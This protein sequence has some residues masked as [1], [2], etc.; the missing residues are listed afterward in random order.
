M[1]RSTRARTCSRS[2]SCSTSWLRGRRPF[3]GSTFI[4]VSSA[5]LR[6]PPTALRSV[7][8]DLPSDLE[9]IVGR[10]LEKDPER[11]VQTAKDVRNELD[12]IRRGLESCAPSAEALTVPGFGGRPAIAV[13]PFENRSGDAEQEFFADG[14]AEDLIARLS[15]WRAFPVIA[16][17]SSFTYKG[18]GTALK[19]VSTELGARYFVQGS[20]RKAG[21]RVR[22]AAQFAD[23]VTGQ[24]VWAQSYGRTSPTYS[25][26]R[27][28]CPGQRILQRRALRGRARGRTTSPHALSRLLLRPG[29]ERD[30]RRRARAVGS[31]A[32]SVQEARRLVPDLSVAML[33]RVLG[34]MAPEVDQR[35]MGA[36]Q[37]AGLV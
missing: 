19:R 16:S 25:P 20:V 7:R 15:L 21:N 29:L 31:G 13:L 22:I 33:R 10:C 9:R 17:S 32:G 24:N 12:S 36:L 4:E 35:M 6:D 2:A 23:A 5:I 14:L 27:T 30:E 11:R 8:G 37:R 18:K 34:A 28:R 3:P 1:G 26:F